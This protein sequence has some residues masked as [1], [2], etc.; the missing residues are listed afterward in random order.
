MW[1]EG[2]YKSEVIHVSKKKQKVW[3]SHEHRREGLRFEQRRC[4]V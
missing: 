3:V 1:G 4:K 2:K